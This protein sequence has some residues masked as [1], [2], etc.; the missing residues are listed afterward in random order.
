MCFVSN[1]VTTENSNGSQAG[2]EENNGESDEGTNIK[3]VMKEAKA[4]AGVRTTRRI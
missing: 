4:A 3:D 2:N 1:D